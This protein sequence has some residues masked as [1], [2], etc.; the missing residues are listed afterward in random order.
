MSE[1]ALVLT[2]A[3]AQAAG[4]TGAGPFTFA[5]LPGV[6][7]VD[8]PVGIAHLGFATADDARAALTEVFGEEPP[9]TVTSAS[10]AE[11]EPLRDNHAASEAQVRTLDEQLDDKPVPRHHGELDQLAADAGLVFPDEAKTVA[12]KQAF[13]E[14][15]RTGEPVG[16]PG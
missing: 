4:Y 9:V 3:D 6:Y 8:R 14:A 7:L 1:T 13:L 12:E 5:G 11:S 16:E 15:A 10:P 2:G